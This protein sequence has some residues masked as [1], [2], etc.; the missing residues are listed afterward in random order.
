[1]GDTRADSTDR[2]EGEST[3]DQG[4]RINAIRKGEAVAAAAAKE[5]FGSTAGKDLGSKGKDTGFPIQEKGEDQATY[6]A[7]VRAYRAKGASPQK[8]ALGEMMTGGG[9]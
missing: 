3:A 7:R 1:M 9:S 8:K 5:K 2:I 4:T 6:M